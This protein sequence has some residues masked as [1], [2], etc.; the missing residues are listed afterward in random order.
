MEVSVGTYI[1]SIARDLGERL[2]L[3]GYVTRLHRSKIAHLDES[4]AKQFNEITLDDVLTYGQIFTQFE[5]IS[6]PPEICDKLRNGLKFSNMLGLEIG[7]KYL[8][9]D[10]GKYTSLIETREDEVR[11]CANNIE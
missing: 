2:G 8:V 1:R 4:L 10:N 7:K 9:L 6:P 11:I 3:S 5:T